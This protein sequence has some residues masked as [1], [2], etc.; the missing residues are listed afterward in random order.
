MKSKAEHNTRRTRDFQKHL[1][2]TG[3]KLTH[4]RLEILH[5]LMSDVNHPSAEEV[6]ERIKPKIPTISF[7]TVYRTLALFECHGIVSRVH[8]LDDKSRYDPNTTHHYHFVCT[9][10]KTIKDFYWSDLDELTVPTEVHRWGEIN[11]RYLEIRGT[12]RD[13]INKG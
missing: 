12:C 13:C 4:Q 1:K 6:Y 10:C 3:L 9:R 5:I 7:D 11:D 2:Q 8:Y